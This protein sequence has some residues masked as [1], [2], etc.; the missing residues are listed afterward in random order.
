M[1]KNGCQKETFYRR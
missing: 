1:R